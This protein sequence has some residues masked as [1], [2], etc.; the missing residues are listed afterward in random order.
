MN[1]S[2]RSELDKIVVFSLDEP[3]YALHL[4]A[5]Q[6]VVRAVEILPLPKAPDIVQG[7]INVQGQ[8]IPVIDVRTRFRLPPREMDLDDRFIIARTS[9]RSVAL[10]VGSVSGIRELADG[11]MVDANQ[12]LPEAEYIRGIAKTS[13]GLILIY[14]LDRFLSL[15]EEQ[16]LDTALSGGKA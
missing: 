8:I 14:D 2:E 3:Y 9:T 4:S 5:V 6:R 13:D 15:D 12:V 7:V 10:A 16:A 11:E 1:S